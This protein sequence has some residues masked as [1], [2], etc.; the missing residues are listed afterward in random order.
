[1][2]RA[3]RRLETARA[4]DLQTARQ[5]GQWLGE[6]E[7]LAGDAATATRW[8]DAL[9]R[10]TPDDLRRVAARVMTDAARATVWLLPA[11]A[12]GAR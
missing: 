10:V 12:G 1:M 9:G 2:E 3:R 6:A 4:F 8:L 11:G 7:M 5:R